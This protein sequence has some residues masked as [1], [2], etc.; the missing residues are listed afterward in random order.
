MKYYYR[1]QNKKHDF[2]DVKSVFVFPTFNIE[3][4]DVQIIQGKNKIIIGIGK[5]T[6]PGAEKF[7][8]DIFGRDNVKTVVTTEG[9]YH[10]DTL[11]KC[12]LHVNPKSGVSPL[13]YCPDL[14]DE[15]L[16]HMIFNSKEFSGMPKI[17]ISADLVKEEFFT[18]IQSVVNIHTGGVT[19]FYHTPEKKNQEEVN[20]VIRDL[21]SMGYETCQLERGIKNIHYGGG[22]LHCITN[23]ILSVKIDDTEANILDRV[24]QYDHGIYEGKNI[25]LDRNSSAKIIQ[26]EASI[27]ENRTTNQKYGEYDQSKYLRLEAARDFAWRE[28]ARK[29]NQVSHTSFVLD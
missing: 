14:C 23:N 17:A 16:K 5:R 10:L 6:K 20:S 4:G 8:Q 27:P 21:E 11:V 24:K 12:D 1:E 9:T 2:S 19:I 22:S 7:F 3:G 18:N 15:Q 29:D 26:R 13:I 28:K 25:V